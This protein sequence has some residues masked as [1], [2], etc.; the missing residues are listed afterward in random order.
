[1]K[2][3]FIGTPGIRRRRA[4]TSILDAAENLYPKESI[5]KIDW[6]SSGVE[7]NEG[8]S[9]DS[10]SEGIPILEDKLYSHHPAELLEMSTHT[11]RDLWREKFGEIN[12]EYRNSRDK[13]FFLGLHLLYRYNQVPSVA[14]D[15]GELAQWKPDCIVTLIDDIFSARE[16]I[17]S[18]GHVSFS[19]QE[20]ALWRAEE[21]MLG[22]VLARLVNKKNPPPNY[23]VSIRHPVTKL[24]D[25]LFSHNKDSKSAIKHNLGRV[26]LSYNISDTRHTT[27]LRQEIDYF[28]QRFHSQENFF[29]FDPLMID[30]LPPVYFVKKLIGA[31]KPLPNELEYDPRDPNWRWPWLNGGNDLRPIAD[32]DDLIGTYPL[33]IPTKEILQAT[34]AIDAQVSN[35]DIRLVDQAHYLA[36]WRP[37]MTR[38][39]GVSSGVR[40]E[41]EFARA[42]GVNLLGYIKENTDA[43]P[44]SSFLRFLHP[45]QNPN[46]FFNK[47]DAD[48]WSNIEKIQ[49]LPP[50][51]GRNHFLR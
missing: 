41:L 6:Q 27:E 47:S 17:H 29:V 4:F 36:L 18:T 45:D 48:F 14:A 12:R 21:L 24:V 33:K 32:D 44:T 10:I 43:L 50:N 39:K 2:V 46:I 5:F 26:Y 20:L 28:R 9:D 38:D 1:M 22:D 49:S 19:L 37:T 30:E 3:L 51:K 15:L 23:L 34:E 13:H 11:Q 8:H 31:S 16:R 40:G 25:L 42:R 7:Q 35:R